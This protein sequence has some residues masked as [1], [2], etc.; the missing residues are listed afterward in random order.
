MMG[1]PELLIVLVVAVTSLLPIVL[2][3]WAIITLQRVR[4]GQRT[5]ESKIDALARQLPR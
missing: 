2:V 1:M 3:V 4:D 5:I